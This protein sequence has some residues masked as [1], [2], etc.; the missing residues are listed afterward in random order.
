MVDEAF[1]RANPGSSPGPHVRISVR[2]TGTGIEPDVQHRVFE[3][4]F[5]TKG[6]KGTGLGLA[7]VYGIVKQNRANIWMDSEVGTGTTFTIF[8]PTTADVAAA[9]EVAPPTTTTGVETILVV[10][11]NEDV[12]DV[13][14]MQLEQRGYVVHTAADAEEA[15]RIFD[16]AAPID[17]LLTDIIM[18]GVSGPALAKQLTSRYPGLA[19][20]FM[21]GYTDDVMVRHSVAESGVAFLQKPFTGEEL[22]Q[23]VR[24]VLDAARPMA[25]VRVD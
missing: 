22:A 18:P 6:L 9:V 4:F 1:A 12:R 13:V 24:R 16:A 5:T 10:E 15:L 8:W 3:P 25:P 19:L 21:S 17:L 20:L 14:C 7:S 23:K 2:D 11:D